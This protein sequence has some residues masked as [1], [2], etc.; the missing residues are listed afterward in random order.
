MKTL[1]LHCECGLER[2][3]R[4]HDGKEIISLIDRSGWEDLPDKD[5]RYGVGHVPGL[6]P[7]CQRVENADTGQ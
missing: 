4:G 2:T 3:F 6:C 1:T 7:K 5:K